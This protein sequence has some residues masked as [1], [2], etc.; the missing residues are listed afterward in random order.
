MLGT[1]L[2]LRVAGPDDEAG[3][4]R[5]EDVVLAEFDRLEALFSVYRVDSA[6]VRWRTAAIDGPGPEVTDVLALAEHWWRV[7]DGA[8]H[9]ATAA[10][11][12]CWRRAATT[13]VPPSDDELDALAGG[14]ATLPYTVVDGRLRRT[15]DATGVD[16]NALAKGW[17]VDRAVRAGRA[18]DGVTR[19]VVNAG[20]DLVHRGDGEVVVAIE[21]PSRPHQ[22]AAPIDRLAISNEA[23]A[24]SG[25]AHRGVRVAG[26]WY[27]HVIDPRTARPVD[28]VRSA[29]VVAPDAATADAVATIVGV[30]P[31]DRSLELVDTLDG[32]SCCLVDADGRVHTDPTWAVRRVR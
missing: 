16:L 5:V 9:P 23:L 27:G 8:F 20:G 14:A 18:V 17:I 10:M 11:T 24:T 32:V 31:V 7:G 28:H 3:A 19:L 15:G 30:W 1:V 26:R 2:E 25:S 22:N 6:L 29:S 4:R 12:A 13:G 21:D